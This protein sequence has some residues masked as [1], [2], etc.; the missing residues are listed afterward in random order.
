MTRSQKRIAYREAA[1]R[2]ATE[3]NLYCCTALLCLDDMDD[4]LQKEFTEY[5]KPHNKEEGSTWFPD[6]GG[7]CEG[8]NHDAQSQRIL[9]LYFMSHATE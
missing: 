6:P 8:I 3:Q 1:K 7:W 2:I 9:A 5:F 4:T